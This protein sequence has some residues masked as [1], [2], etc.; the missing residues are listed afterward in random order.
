MSNTLAYYA[1]AEL[2]TAIKSLRQAP[3]EMGKMGLPE[4]KPS[5]ERKNLPP[6]WR[7]KMTVFLHFD[8]IQCFMTSYNLLNEQTGDWRC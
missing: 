8:S 4:L 3:W 7:L 5:L 2:I 1:D 6:E